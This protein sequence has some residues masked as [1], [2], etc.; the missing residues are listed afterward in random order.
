[1]TGFVILAF[2]GVGIVMLLALLAE[3]YRGV[4]RR[5]R[6]AAWREIHD[7]VHDGLGPGEET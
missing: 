7:R 4:L 1:M 5:R 2:A 3:V 6:A